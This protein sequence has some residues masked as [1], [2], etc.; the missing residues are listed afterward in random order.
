[1]AF[2]GLKVSLRK[3]LGKE[4]VKKLR[5]AGR[6]PGIVYGPDMEPLPI[7]IDLRDFI[8]FYHTHSHSIVELK[9]DGESFLAVLKD[10]QWDYIK[11][12]PLHCDFYHV[13]K[14]RPFEITV[15]VEYVGEPVGIRKG[16]ILEIMLN[17]IEIRTTVDKMPKKITIDISGLDVGD[18][19]QVKDVKPPE[20]VEIV[21]EPEEV[22][23]VVAAPTVE[24]VE[25][26]VA[27]AEEEEAAPEV[28]SKGKAAEEEEESEG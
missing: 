16:G 5:R 13:S 2:P 4:K 1:M 26:A 3:E 8:H 23:V 15:P 7:S 21:E 6:V 22:L 25:E 19:L 27:E 9:A 28:I 11:D 10:V 18:S 17:E 20:G 24:E 12:R 14:D